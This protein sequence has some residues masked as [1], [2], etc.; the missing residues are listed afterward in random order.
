MHF[1]NFL[2]KK[3]MKEHVVLYILHV[4]NNSLFVKYKVTISSIIY[5]AVPFT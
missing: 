5:S 4:V 3:E 2:D 1:T